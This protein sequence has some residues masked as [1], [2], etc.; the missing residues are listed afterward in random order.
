MGTAR[1]SQTGSTTL[2]RFRSLLQQLWRGQAVLLF[3]DRILND[4]QV[5]W[6]KGYTELLEML[7]KHKVRP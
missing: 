5:V 2:A 4:V 1:G 6:A 7:E 3:P